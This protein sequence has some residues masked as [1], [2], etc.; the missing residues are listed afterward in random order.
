MKILS[1]SILRLL[2]TVVIKY[3]AM[4]INK[5]FEETGRQMHLQITEISRL[6]CTF[7]V[8]IS[9]CTPQT[10]DNDLVSTDFNKISVR[11]KQRGILFPLDKLV[12]KVFS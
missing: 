6:T 5:F 11:N 3:I 9:H 7:A 12:F 2:L 4:Q 10:R 8:W 1:K